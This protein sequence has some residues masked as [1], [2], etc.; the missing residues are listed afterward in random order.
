MKFSLSPLQLSHACS[1][2][3]LVVII[4]IAFPL[5]QSSTTCLSLPLISGRPEDH[6]HTTQPATKPFPTLL[7]LCQL[8]AQHQV[9][10][11][12]HINHLPGGRKAV[13]ESH[14]GHF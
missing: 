11:L 10:V 5:S 4:I 3:S 1:T 9:L 12:D 8:E 6:K 14:G 7:T 2:C 13:Q